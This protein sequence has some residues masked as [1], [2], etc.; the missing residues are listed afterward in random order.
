MKVKQM[1]AVCA[2]ALL[3]V[4]SASAQAAL[5][6]EDLVPGSGDGY[7][8]IDTAQGL[9]FL[10][11]TLTAG[12]SPNQILSGSAGYIDMGFRYA[13]RAEVISLFLNA[14]PFNDAS[15][16]YPENYEPATKL[17]DLMGVLCCPSPDLNSAAGIYSEGALFEFGSLSVKLSDGTG[18][19][20]PYLGFVSPDLSN[21]NFGHYLVRPQ[22]IPI[23][24]ALV[25]FASGALVL[26]GMVRPHNR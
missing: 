24:G 17:L 4:V 10:D 18:Q 21:P 13:D 2:F 25:L 7:L 26:I 5:I 20:Q 8:T 1:I 23:P 6:S 11:L 12:F 15:G 3:A 16:Y 9:Q 14:G 19:M 22:V